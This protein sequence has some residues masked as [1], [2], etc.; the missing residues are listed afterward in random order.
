MAINETLNILDK[1]WSKQ[2]FL[3]QIR[4]GKGSNEIVQEFI[5]DNKK[6]IEIAIN[7]INEK[8]REL[9]DHME[10][11]ANCEIKL[12]HE[13]KIKEKTPIVKNLQQSNNK[14][15]IVNIYREFNLSLFM[16]KW[17]NKFVIGALVMI[18]LL[19]L[20]KQAWA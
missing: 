4:R 11:L 20:T 9:L 17:S 12:I 15:P 18:S 1:S 8:D 10:V 3:N 16:H 2:R 5:K 14:N 7:L 13:L 6:N 19:S